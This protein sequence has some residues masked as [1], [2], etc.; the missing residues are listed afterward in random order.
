MPSTYTVKSCSGDVSV[1]DSQS[2]GPVIVLLNGNSA[3]KEIFLKQ[4]KEL[5]EKYRIIAIDLPGHGGADAT[6]PKTTYNLGGI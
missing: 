1:W 5:G 3:C 6:D 2:K 4:F